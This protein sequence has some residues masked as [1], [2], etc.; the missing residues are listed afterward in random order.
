M[1]GC[2]LVVL[3][4]VVWTLVEE[5]LSSPSR[6]RRRRDNLKK[7]RGIGPKISLFLNTHG[8]MTFDQLARAEV[9]WLQQLLDDVGY[10]V[11]DPSSWP[12]QARELAAEKKGFALHR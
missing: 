4:G 12:Q 1:A 9:R 11:S 5:Y 8:I 10:K 2:F 7:I 3:V 6:K